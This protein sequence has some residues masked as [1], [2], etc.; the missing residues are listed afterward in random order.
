MSTFLN[1]FIKG[2]KLFQTDP[3]QQLLRNSTSKC[4]TF[5]PLN[6]FLD[7]R[8]RNVLSGNQGF[9]WFLI[10]PRNTFKFKMLDIHRFFKHVSFYFF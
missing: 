1:S 2:N 5:P 7:Q 9:L 10:K 8:E 4:D 6:R 3:N